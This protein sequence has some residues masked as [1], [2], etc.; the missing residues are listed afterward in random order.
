[1]SDPTINLQGASLRKRVKRYKEIANEIE[2]YLTKHPNE[3]GRFQSQFNQEINGIFR[4]LMIFEKENLAKGN[5]DKVYK[6]KHIFIK[7]FREDF[8]HGDYIV[9]SL[10]KPFGYAGDFKIIDDVYRNSPQTHGFDR[11]FDNYVQVSSI[12]I[13]IRNRKEDIKRKIMEMINS[14]GGEKIKILNLASGP[15]REWKELLSADLH[16]SKQISVDCFDQDENANHYAKDLLGEGA[17]FI[18]FRKE[19]ALWMALKKDIRNNFVE[20]YDLIYSLG[21]FDYLDHRIAARLSHNMGLLLKPNGNLIVANVREKYQNPS[22]HF[23]EWVGDWN[24]IYRSEEEYRQIF[25]DAGYSAD[26][27]KIESE[28]QGIIQYAVVSP[29]S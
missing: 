5:E 1:M 26:Q 8:L 6:L 3:W 7:R 15:C 25:L 19:N 2:A 21:L 14:R 20:R 4:D 27:I 10:K 9:W 13:A 29:G 24:L 28:Q 17:N 18:Q 23:L 11:L 22:V 16:Q 12:A